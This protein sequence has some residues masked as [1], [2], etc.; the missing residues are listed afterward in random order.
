MVEHCCSITS[1]GLGEHFTGIARDMDTYTIRSP[2]GVTAG[3]TPF[4]FPAM[5]PLWM[6]PVAV[7]C[8]N[9]FVVKPSERD[10][11]ATM[12]LCELAN[13]AGFPK[14]VPALSCPLSPDRPAPAALS[15]FP[16]PSC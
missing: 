16:S 14:G 12:M 7:V 11:G 4:N 10:P 3:I 2:L 5:I 1:L 15:P 8:G 13:E 6:F 9:T